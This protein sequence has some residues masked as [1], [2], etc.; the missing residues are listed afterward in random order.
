MPIQ[1]LTQLDAEP[2]EKL[3][4][5]VPEAAA[6][7]LEGWVQQ[8]L[9]VAERLQLKAGCAKAHVRPPIFVTLGLVSLVAVRF[10]HRRWHDG[11]EQPNVSRH[12]R[13]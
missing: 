2:T 1:A 3:A 7:H 11:H 9:E 8:P 4:Q 5:P 6:L 12:L 10:W 13:G